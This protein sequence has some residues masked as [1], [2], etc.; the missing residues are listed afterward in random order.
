MVENNLVR[1]NKDSHGIKVHL[2]LKLAH[3]SNIINF[4]YKINIYD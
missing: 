1:L 3:L 4:N 2:A